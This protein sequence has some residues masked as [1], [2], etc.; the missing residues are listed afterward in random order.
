PANVDPVGKEVEIEGRLFLVIGVLAKL[1]SLFSDSNPEDNVAQ[2]PA[3]TFWKLHPEQKDI[4]IVAKARSQEDMPRA[5]QQIE[6]ALR[7]RRGLTSQEDS[8]F[9][10]S[11]QNTFTD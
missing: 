11:T 3:G 4:L 6:Q 2:M 1:K 9:A 10:I 5:I 7:I 8:D